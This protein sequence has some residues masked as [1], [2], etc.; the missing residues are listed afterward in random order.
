MLLKDK[1]GLVTGGGDGIGRATCLAF[2]QHGARVAVSD[3]NEEAGYGTVELIKKSGGEATFIQADVSSEEQ[4]DSLISRITAHYGGLH[5]ASNNAA[6]GGGYDALTEIDQ[7]TWERVQSVNLKGPWLC[8][9]YEIPAMLASG[10]GTIVN[11]SSMAG[12]RGIAHQAAYCASKG[13]VIGLTKAAA[14]EYAKRGIR[15]N[16]IC[17]GAIRTTGLQNFLDATPGLEKSLTSE[18][19]MGRLGEIEEIAEAAV[20]LCSEQ[21]SFMTGHIMP[22]EGGALVKSI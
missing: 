10:G 1:I 20:F 16:A 17:P 6:I 13:G 18:H 15:I 4:V 9:K 11:I 19:A 21:S 8:L 3:V 14:S 2:A 5:L 12:Y 22:I 7:A